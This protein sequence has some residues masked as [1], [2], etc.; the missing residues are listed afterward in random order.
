[1]GRP[2][3]KKEEFDSIIKQ[4]VQMKDKDA[5]FIYKIVNIYGNEKYYDMY[6]SNTVFEKFVNDMP[7][8]HK[9]AFDNGAGGELKPGQYPPKM[10]SV[11]SSSRFCYLAL[12]NGIN[13]TI[14]NEHITGDPVFEYKCP[15]FS[16]T[17]NHAPHLDAY[18]AESN[19]YFEVKC[20]EIFDSHKVVMDKDYWDLVYG[21]GNKF[22]FEVKAKPDPMPE[23]FEIPLSEFKLESQDFSMFDIKQLICHLLGIAK[24]D[25][26]NKKLIYLFFRPDPMKKRGGSELYRKMTLLY[27]GCLKEVTDKLCNEIKI[28]FN[29]KPIKSFCENSK[30]TLMAIA[31]KSDVMEPLTNNNMEVLYK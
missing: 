17:E 23:T 8:K 25:G 27:D 18:I 29:S 24:K 19:C 7:S 13:I 22:G 3:M 31:E 4:L 5:L 16:N 12:S 9:K 10:A 20:H 14:D 30:I 11:A 1:M 21:K 28:V 15:I 6:Y 2:I 26:T